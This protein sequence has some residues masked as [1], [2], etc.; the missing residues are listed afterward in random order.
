VTV[1]QLC[2]EALAGIADPAGRATVLA[3][4]A[5]ARHQ[6]MLD[7]SARRDLHEALTLDP[8]AQMVMEAA[9]VLSRP[10]AA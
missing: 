4:A 9:S 8:S 3:T 5:I 1:R 7:A 2:A 10:I 6:L